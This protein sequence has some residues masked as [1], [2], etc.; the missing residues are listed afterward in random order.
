MGVVGLCAC[1]QDLPIG[2]LF[3][4]ENRSSGGFVFP[5]VGPFWAT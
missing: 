1:P 2:L 5:F 4:A 3:Q